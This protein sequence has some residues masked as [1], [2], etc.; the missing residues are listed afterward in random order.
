MILTL[1]LHNELL[2]LKVLFFLCH[3]KIEYILTADLFIKTHT[4]EFEKEFEFENY[5][6]R[7]F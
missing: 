5:Y 7:M 6:F 2:S 1:S 3:E 4:T